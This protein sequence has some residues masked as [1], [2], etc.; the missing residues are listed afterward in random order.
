MQVGS[1]ELWISD[2][3]RFRHQAKF[4]FTIDGQAIVDEY[5]HLDHNLEPYFASSFGVQRRFGNYNRS[6]SNRWSDVGNIAFHS[7]ALIEDGSLHRGLE[8]LQSLH[9]QKLEA[10][11]QKIKSSGILEQVI[12]LLNASQLFPN[13][14]T[15]SEVMSEDVFLK[16]AN[17]KVI[18]IHDM[19]DGFRSDC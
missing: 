15:I 11:K 2:Q 12:E 16:D 4:E 8:W 1:V 10:E 13:G 14:E 6:L 18:S 7:S 17:G 9:V 19:S 5:R 3:D